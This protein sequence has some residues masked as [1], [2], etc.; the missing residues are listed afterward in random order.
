MTLKACF[1][2]FT[3][4]NFNCLKYCDILYT[5][6]AIKLNIRLDVYMLGHTAM[7]YVI[8]QPNIKCIA[9]H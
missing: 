5:H 8:T 3:F 6:Q 2:H 4:Y 9:Y 1:K 7:Y